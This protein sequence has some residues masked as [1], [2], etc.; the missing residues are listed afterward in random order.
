[1]A[2]IVPVVV[3]LEE[4]YLDLLQEWS[5]DDDVKAVVATL[6]EIATRNGWTAEMLLGGMLLRDALKSE[7][8]NAH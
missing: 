4:E 5:N 3:L 6:G 7:L 8:R 1:M 2:K